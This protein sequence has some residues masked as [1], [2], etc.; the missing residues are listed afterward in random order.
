MA[1]RPEHAMYYHTTAGRWSGAIDFVAEQPSGKPFWSS[2]GFSDFVPYVGF[3]DDD[4]ALQW[5]ADNDHNW[6]LGEEQPS[7]TLWRG[8]NEVELQVNLVRRSGP[9]SALNEVQFGFI[10]TPVKPMAPGWRN[11]SLHF[12]RLC[13]AKIA[14]FYGVGHGGG[15]GLHDTAGLL[16]TLKVEVPPGK[17]PDEVL[18]HLS[19][20]V[21]GW[22]D[23]LSSKPGGVI[24]CP[25]Q[26]AQM[27]FEGYRSKAFATLFPGDW[28]IYP[29][30]GW[31][32]LAPTRSYQ[33]FFTWHFDKWVKHLSVRGVY[34]DEAYFPKDSNVFNGSG[35]IMPDGS[36]R[37]SLN[38][39]L[40][41][42]FMRRVRQVFVDRNV[43][44]FIWVHTSNFMAP[45]AISWCQVAMFGEDRAP[46][47]TVDYID[48]APEV[49]FR[50]IGRS[51]K[52]GLAPIWMNQVGRGGGTAKGPIH[53]MARQVCGW[54]WMFDTGVELHA[55]SRGRA[56]QWQRVH[57]GIDKD[58]V[59]YH[60]YWKQNLVQS[61]DDDVIV[62][63]W[64]R[65]GTALLQAFNLARSN[66]MA[67]LTLDAKA[68][69]LKGH[70][71][72]YDLESTPALVALKEK[73]R[74]YDAG[75]IQDQAELRQLQRACTETGAEPYRLADLKVAGTPQRV[76]VD[77]PARDFVL[78]VAE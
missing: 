33:D 75:K 59:R 13:N 6:V 4:R 48:T 20:G 32:H 60:G 25:F 71:K 47:A 27:L 34:F 58:D 44:P 65:P 51:Q 69:R 23:K 24:N 3:S 68:L 72:V 52:Y 8:D 39:M 29:P 66:K 28:R 2:A 41:R 42:A 55:A 16:E 15:L 76:Q 38:L 77:I 45:H 61:A 10:A 70:A 73:L 22:I 7:V 31:F 78:L 18:Q 26:N 9:L 63:V 49:L 11:L 74:Q 67:R 56:Q 43:E 5:F 62:S 36:I 14:F 35:K 64:S 50:A 40:Q 19:P 21:Q 46:T 54:C 1:A 17:S 30:G 12:S 57:W 53:R 37:P